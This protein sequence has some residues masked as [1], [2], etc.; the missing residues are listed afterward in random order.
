MSTPRIVAR[1]IFEDVAPTVDDAGTCATSVEGQRKILKQIDLAQKAI[2][3]RIDTEGMLYDWP[4]PVRTGCFALPIDCESDRNIF[5]NGFPAVQRDQWFEG[6]LAWGRN[7]YGTDCRMQCIDEGQFAIPLPLPKVFSARI[8]IV[9]EAQGD[10]GQVVTLE[11]INQYGDRITEELTLLGN[12]QP[13]YTNAMAYDVTMLSKPRTFGA[14][15]LQMRY[16]DGARFQIGVPVTAR[17]PAQCTHGYFR[18]KKLPTRYGTSCQQVVIKGKLKTWTIDREGDV[19]PFG[20]IHAWRFACQAIAAQT[21]GEN[22]VYRELLG[23]ALN[24]LSRSMQDSDPS[25]NV[26]MVKMQSGF[27]GNPSW[28]SGRGRCWN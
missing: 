18:R 10:A 5:I 28:A 26:S 25:G 13:V 3:K 7:G 9:A 1:D 20:D 11:F 21:R 24:E 16:D 19:L 15:Q 12:G 14:I 17:Y 2:C 8:A 23:E 22:A 6:K 4:V 27:A